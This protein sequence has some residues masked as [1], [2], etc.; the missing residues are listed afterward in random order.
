MPFPPRYFCSD[1]ITY[2][3][4]A[5]K[6]SPPNSNDCFN[7]KNRSVQKKT[8]KATKQVYHVKKD[9]R[10]GKNSDLT[11]RIEMSTVEETSASSVE[12][13]DP[14]VEYVSNNI[15]EQKPSSAGRQDDLKATGSDGTGLTGVPTGLTGTT[16]LTGANTCLTGASNES[17]N[18]SKAKN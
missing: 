18:S 12:Q 7:H 15:A 9:G 8:H 11:Q 17:G 3:E 16:G 1:Y 13:I 2:K 10:L 6:K 5:I 4:S 14:N